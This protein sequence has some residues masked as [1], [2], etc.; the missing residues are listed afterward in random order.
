MRDE[1]QTFP[2]TA[3][4]TKVG[5]EQEFAPQNRPSPLAY[6]DIQSRAAPL[7]DPFQ[8]TVYLAQLARSGRPK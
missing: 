2:E 1:H 5:S 3:K 4:T 7:A 8:F 6:P